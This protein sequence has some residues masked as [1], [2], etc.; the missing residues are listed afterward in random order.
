MF[1]NGYSTI[2]GGVNCGFFTPNQTNSIQLTVP[3]NTNIPC[4]F[5]Q[6]YQ[7][8]QNNNFN[9]YN[10]CN[11]AYCNNFAIKP[12][13]APKTE[14]VVF[15]QSSSVSSSPNPSDLEDESGTW[16]VDDQADN[17]FDGIDTDVIAN[18]DDIKIS[19]FCCFDTNESELF[20]FY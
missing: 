2:Y 10:R 19:N 1:S 17:L 11:M 4:Q 18:D 3:Q 16:D 8:I 9:N 7:M 12:N 5:T 15:E 14:T 20:S 6:G 13:V